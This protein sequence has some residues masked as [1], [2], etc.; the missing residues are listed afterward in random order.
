M[1]VPV[2]LA[3]LLYKLQSDRLKFKEVFTILSRQQLTD[4]I[5]K[6]GTELKW[7]P[8]QINEDLVIART[9][10]SFFSGSWGEQVT[11]LFDSNRILI[12]SIC[13]PEKRISIV[14]MG[15][16]KKNVNRLIEEIEKTA[17]NLNLVK[18]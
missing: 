2:L 14:S 10:P 12:N 9:H 13:D 1:T 8:E 7:F 17:A 15:R 6:V 3:A 5:E 18:N 4:I 16:N 11:I